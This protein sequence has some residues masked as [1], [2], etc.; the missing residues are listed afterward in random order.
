MQAWDHSHHRAV[1][2]GPICGVVMT[3]AGTWLLLSAASYL[4]ARETPQPFQFP[5]ITGLSL[6]RLAV[7]LAESVI[8]QFRQRRTHF[9][10]ATA[11]IFNHTLLSLRNEMLFMW[12]IQLNL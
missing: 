1:C 8:C 5:F 6:T 2:Y 9:H 4:T 11:F 10:T 7:D 12:N 3:R